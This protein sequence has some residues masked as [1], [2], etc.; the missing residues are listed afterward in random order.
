M[1]DPQ[2]TPTKEFLYEMS[3]NTSHTHHEFTDSIDVYEVHANYVRFNT[4]KRAKAKCPTA[5]PT[6]SLVDLIVLL[7]MHVQ[8]I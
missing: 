7:P 4:V 1:H 5:A 2:T 3:A 8:Y 6:P